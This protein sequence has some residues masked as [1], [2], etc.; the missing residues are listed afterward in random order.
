MLPLGLRQPPGWAPQIL[1]SAPGPGPPP[2]VGA[3]PRVLVVP[4]DSGTLR[5]AVLG[6]PGCSADVSL[7]AAPSQGSWLTSLGAARI[8]GAAG[9]PPAASRG[10]WDGGPLLGS[11]GPVLPAAPGA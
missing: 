10:S 11:G 7:S 9:P 2:G 1:A 6:L 5:E 4:P 3:G 8:P